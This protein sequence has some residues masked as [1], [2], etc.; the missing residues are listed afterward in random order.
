MIV[1]H[2]AM[3]GAPQQPMMDMPMAGV[4]HHDMAAMSAGPAISLMDVAMGVGIAAEAVLIAGVA[5]GLVRQP[6]RR[7]GDS[8]YHAR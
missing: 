3:M 2:V 4:H 5:I 1:V 6:V 7:T 8:G